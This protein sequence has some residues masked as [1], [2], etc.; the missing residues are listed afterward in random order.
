MKTRRIAGIVA[1]LGVCGVA[2]ADTINEF[3]LRDGGITY[4][5]TALIGGGSGAGSASFLVGGDDH[6]FQNW[7]WFRQADMGREQA[8]GRQVEGAV[9]APNSARMTYVQGEGN[10]NVMYSLEYTLTQ[11]NN[12]TGMVQ[13]SWTVRN[14]DSVP[15][16]VNLFSYTDFD[17]SGSA[18][19][20][21]ATINGVS[22]QFQSIFDSETV[23]A[24]TASSTALTRWEIDDYSD[25]RDKLENGAVDDLA[26]ARSPFG[27]GDYTGAFQWL[28]ELA[29]RGDELGRD[30]MNGSLVKIVQIPEPASLLLLGL[31]AALIRRKG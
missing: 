26:N 10:G 16:I 17:L 13:I 6:L 11:L 20:D 28:M 8:L 21:R 30:M 4:S 24:L 19:D 14:L 23:A 25:I 31:G 15:R 12:L 9:T 7:W 29:P 2:L 18:G 22:N 5:E 1:A 3:T 27:P